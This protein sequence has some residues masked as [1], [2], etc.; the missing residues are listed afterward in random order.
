MPKSLDEKNPDVS[1]N[2][3]MEAYLGNSNRWDCHGVKSG[4]R[5]AYQT[6]KGKI[7]VRSRVEIEQMLWQGTNCCDRD[8]PMGSTRLGCRADC[9]CFERENWRDYLCSRS[10]REGMR[11]VVSKDATPVPMSC[12]T[13]SINTLPSRSYVWLQYVSHWQGVPKIMSLKKCD[14]NIWRYQ[15]EDYSS[16]D[17]VWKRKAGNRAHILEG[18]RRHWSFVARLLPLFVALTIQK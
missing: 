16:M 8:S 13:I 11:I 15:I 17:W 12:S 1:V 10:G 9:Q 6:G 5:K 18:L 2:E 4:I 3:L 7:I 14:Q